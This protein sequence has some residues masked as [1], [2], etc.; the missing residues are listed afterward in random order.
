MQSNLLERLDGWGRCP[1]E[2][3]CT[4]L[5]V[6]VTFPLFVVPIALVRAPGQ[7]VLQLI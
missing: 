5:I 7:S 2:T 6:E 3:F 1:S 4:L